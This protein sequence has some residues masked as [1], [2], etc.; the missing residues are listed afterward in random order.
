MRNR[1]TWFGFVLGLGFSLVT[2]S[3]VSANDEARYKIVMSK[4]ERLCT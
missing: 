2:A 3:V 4:N 1:G